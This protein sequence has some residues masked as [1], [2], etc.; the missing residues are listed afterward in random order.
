MTG[1]QNMHEEASASGHPGPRGK[2]K[3]RRCLAA[4]AL[5]SAVMFM[6]ATSVP[7]TATRGVGVVGIAPPVTS[8]TGCCAWPELTLASPP[9]SR[10]AR[11]GPA[12]RS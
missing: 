2:R 7:S 10:L 5:I 11:F 9:R 6:S 4:A 1:T 3:A 12:D 8:E